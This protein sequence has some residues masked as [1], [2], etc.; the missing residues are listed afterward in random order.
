MRYAW[1]LALPRRRF[2]RPPALSS[3]WL[4]RRD[5]LAHGGSFQAVSRS[6]DQERAIA[7]L[8]IKHDGYSF[9]QSNDA[10]AITSQKT[11][12]DQLDTAVRIRY[13]QVRR[14]PELVALISVV[15]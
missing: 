12:A 1:E 10:I 3:C 7:G 9:L 15:E 2:N 13:P 5:L 6:V 8:A 4:V 11:L 14:R